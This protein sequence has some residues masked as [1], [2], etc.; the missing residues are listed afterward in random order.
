MESYRQCA[1]KASRDTRMSGDISTNSEHYFV[2][3][4]VLERSLRE[5]YIL[6]LRKITID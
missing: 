1:K 5:M 6:G 2:A 3:R 4:Y